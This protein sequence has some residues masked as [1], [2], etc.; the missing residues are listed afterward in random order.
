[1]IFTGKIEEDL[2]RRDFTMNAVAA[3][4]LRGEVDPYHGR[5]DIEK[6]LIRGIGDPRLRFEEDA[7]RILRGIRFAA[8][9]D[10]EIEDRTL[11]V[12]KE[13]AGL[14]A[15]ISAERIREEFFK[16]VSAQNSG[17]GLALLLETGVLPYI[18]GEDCT[19]HVSKTE[20]E[21]LHLL[22]EN[23]DQTECRLRYR[24]PLVYLCFQREKALKAIEIMGYSNEMKKRLEQA[25]T[26]LNDLTEIQDKT[27][28]KRLIRRIGQNGYRYLTDLKK[29]QCLAFELDDTPLKNQVAL[30]ATIRSGGEAV[31]IQDLAV[32]GGDLKEIG[33]REGVRIGEILELLLDIV[34]ENP[35]KNKKDILLQTADCLKNAENQADKV[36]KDEEHSCV[37]GYISKDE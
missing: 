24:V 18:L 11:Q 6:G 10:F 36:S 12:M 34:H 17:K 5:S 30:F 9:L 27:G 4:P 28:L 37:R 3:S 23:I 25:V 20:G 26:L 35:E 16:T 22:V 21:K 15:H 19:G 7:L 1:M 2:R 33:I 8:Q 32:N 14:L 29:Q 13:K 31:F